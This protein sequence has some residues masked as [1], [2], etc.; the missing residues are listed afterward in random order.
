MPLVEL[1]NKETLLDSV[2]R[3]FPKNECVLFY[4]GLDC[5]LVNSDG[6][7]TETA[8]R[9]PLETVVVRDLPYNYVPEYGEHT[10]VIT[11]GV[12]PIKYSQQQTSKT[13]MSVLLRD[14]SK[15]GA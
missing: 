12:Y 10:P 5:N 9:T 3:L 14:Q 7:K 15:D 1:Q 6:C 11:L 4:R 13:G 2:N 8:D